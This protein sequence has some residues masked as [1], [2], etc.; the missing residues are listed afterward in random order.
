MCKIS[1]D[2]I[3]VNFNSTDYTLQCIESVQS[4]ANLG[5]MRIIVV[6]NN[7]DDDP[8]RIIRQYPNVHLIR[9]SKNFGFGKAINFA[10]KS[11]LSKYII[12]LN[13]ELIMSTTDSY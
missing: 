11:T 2:A 1:I 13:P 6:D 9:N 5:Q 7:S 4:N 3:I 10:L 12:L 8:G